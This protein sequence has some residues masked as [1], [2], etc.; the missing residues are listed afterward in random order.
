MKKQELRTQEIIKNRRFSKLYEEKIKNHFSPIE[1]IVVYNNYMPDKG[2][3]FCEA[4]TKDGQTVSLALASEIYSKFRP[5]P[6]EPVTFGKGTFINPEGY[7]EQYYLDDEHPL[8]KTYT[9]KIYIWMMAHF[10]H[11]IDSSEVEK[12]MLVS[13]RQPDDLGFSHFKSYIRKLGFSELE[14]AFNE[15]F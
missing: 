9:T 2:G 12:L 15:P 1:N 3:L 4:I 11:S 13:S 7:L 14:S 5:G 8:D 6:T 10:L